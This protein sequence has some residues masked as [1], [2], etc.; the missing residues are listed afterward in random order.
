MPLCWT[1]RLLHRGVNQVQA[2]LVPEKVQSITGG[3]PTR[4]GLW[5]VGPLAPGLG[6]LSH[7]DTDICTVNCPPPAS[8]GNGGVLYRGTSLTRKRTPP[9]P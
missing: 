8:A 5:R 2:D 3:S 1:G 6:F 7:L 9:G 4:I